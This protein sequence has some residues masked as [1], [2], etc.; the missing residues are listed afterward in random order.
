VD[1]EVD[2]KAGHSEW[3][4]QRDL[5]EAIVVTC[6]GSSG[7][8]VSPWPKINGTNPPSHALRRCDITDLFRADE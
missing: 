1:S 8:R 7:I 5:H 4:V 6:F 2:K 3:P